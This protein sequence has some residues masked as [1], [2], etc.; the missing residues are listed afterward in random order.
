MAGLVPAIHVF[1][2]AMLLKTRMTG[3]SSAKTRFARLPGHDALGGL[4]Q[5]SPC[6]TDTPSRKSTA[7]IP[8]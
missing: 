8:P 7:G 1:A 6:D 3:M 4:S 2:A 5:R